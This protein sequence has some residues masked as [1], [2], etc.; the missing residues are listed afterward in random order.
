MHE[1]LAQGSTVCT[2]SFSKSKFIL[3]GVCGFAQ[4]ASLLRLHF[5]LSRTLYWEIEITS[6]RLGAVVRGV[7]VNSGTSEACKK[8]FPLM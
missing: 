8:S 1:H 6:L 7:R 3:L 4:T 5:T 2:L